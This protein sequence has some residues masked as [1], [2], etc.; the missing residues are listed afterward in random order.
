LTERSNLKKC[1]LAGLMTLVPMV[2]SVAVLEFVVG[3][4]D[5][6]LQLLP[7]GLQPDSFL[8]WHVPGLGLIL[9]LCLTLAVGMATRHYIGGQLLLQ[10]ELLVKRI[11]LVRAIYGASKQ[12]L[13]ALFM[14]GSDSFKRAVLVE[15][16]RPGMYAIGLVTGPTR[17][18]V[19]SVG[20]GRGQRLLNIYL[21]H[22]PNPT[23][24]IY[25]AIPEEQAVPLDMTVEEALKTIISGGIITPPS[26]DRRAAAEG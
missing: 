15:F 13:E 16:P 6:M 1:F 3:L 5:S 4:M 7:K 2:L 10:W 25:V 26:G 22:T 14:T 24:G 23:A 11:P 19:A 12:L 21:P 17:G 18:E 8:P 9:A 20:A